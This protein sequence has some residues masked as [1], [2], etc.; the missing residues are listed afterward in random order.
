MANEPEEKRQPGYFTENV[1][2]V[3]P[4]IL[5]SANAE[6]LAF[7]ARYRAR[8]GNAPVW[9]SVAGYD[10]GHLAADVVHA[11]ASGT[12][13]TTDP[14]AIHA[15]VL[16]YLVTL[17]S[18][19]QRTGSFWFDADHGRCQAI[20]NGRFSRG[21]IESAPL[22]LVPV[23]TPDNTEIASGVR[24][25]PRRYARLQR[26]VCSGV[27]VNEFPRIDISQASF[28]ADF[29]LWLRWARDAGVA[30]PDPTDISFPDM[31]SGQFDRARP[32]ELGE[33]PDGTVHRLWRV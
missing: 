9:Q 1:Y 26:V 22:Q 11:L 23:T 3:S 25:L 29:Y 21:H 13:A 10:S 2:G 18:P 12:N 33:M 28:G 16:N 24:D 15:A 20:R 31:I 4:V 17:N 6:I 14:H 7:A 19:A 5:G 30:A 8:F 27:F 32:A